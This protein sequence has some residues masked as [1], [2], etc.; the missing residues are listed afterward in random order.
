MGCVLRKNKERKSAHL[1]FD[2]L[3]LNGEYLNMHA[4]KKLIY[5][6]LFLRAFSTYTKKEIICFNSP[7]TMYIKVIN[8]FTDPRWTEDVRKKY[9]KKETKK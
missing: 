4:R 8:L 5:T 9:L 6:M 1:T 3:N 7:K 2:W